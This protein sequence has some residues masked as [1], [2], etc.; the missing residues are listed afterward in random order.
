MKKPFRV[1]LYLLFLCV[2]VRYVFSDDGELP[3]RNEPASE[4]AE[5]ILKN[6]LIGGTEV[7]LSNG[8]VMGWNILV[9]KDSWAKPTANSIYKNFTDPWEWEVSDSFTVNQ[10]GHPAQGLMYFSAGRANGFNFYQSTLF[11]FFGSFTWETLCE[12]NQ[13]SVNDLIVTV[14][15]SFSYGEILYR[16]YLEACAAGVPAIFA[17]IINP[18]AGFHRLVTGWKP[19]DN[20]RNLYLFRTYIGAAYNQTRYSISTGNEELYYFRG[21]H[22]DAGIKLI[23]GNPFEQE[24]RIPFE[25]F[26][27]TLSLG[28]DGVN[29]R[30]LRIISDGYLLSFSPVFSNTNMMSTGPSLHMDFMSTG[31]TD[32]SDISSVINLYSGAL[33]WTL[34]YQHL[35][36][37]DAVFQTKLHFGFSFTGASLFYTPEERREINNY[38]TGLN[39][40]FIFNL[41]HKKLGG[42]ET[43]LYG[44]ILWPYPGSSAISKG[45]VYWLFTDITYSY[46]VSKRL[47]LGVTHSFA[48]ER[49]LFGNFPN[50]LK[51][52]NAVKTFVAWNF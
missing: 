3:E 38:G 21:P 1:F 19:P 4:T 44:Y 12:S 45:T 36:S 50:T 34:K 10:I 11:S 46:P 24:S 25:H 41:E 20:G 49:G 30:D 6:V 39:S 48:L 13:A 16:L 43:S 7:M 14:T 26:E 28:T 18:M 22:A 32:W 40:K 52:S 5:D 47:S 17:A 27:L 51:Y 29:H 9:G 35:L 15:G 33:N 8:I 37:Q 23:Y 31:K 42:I 2:N